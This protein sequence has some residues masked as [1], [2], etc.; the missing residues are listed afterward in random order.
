MRSKIRFRR[1]Q[2]TGRLEKDLLATFQTN[3]IGTIHVINAFM[4]LI[5]Q[6]TVKK[7]IALSTG[8]GDIDFIRENDVWMGVGY[9]ISKAAMN[10]AIA[11]F[12]AQYRE[13]GVL[14]M[15]ISPGLVNTSDTSD[16]ESFFIPKW[17]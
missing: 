17:L 3:V 8:M 4:P 1:G 13:K 5:L 2:E 10:M 12:S 15:G 7:V 9:G 6:G 11:K 14:F 16:C